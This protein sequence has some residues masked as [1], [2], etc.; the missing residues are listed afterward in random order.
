MKLSYRW[1]A[2]SLGGLLVLSLGAAFASCGGDD[3]DA[4]KDS[5]GASSSGDKG[6]KSDATKTGDTNASDANPGAVT[7]TDKQY[8]KDVCV[9][10]NTYMDGVLKSFSADASVAGDEAAIIKKIGPLLEAFG[11]DV[12][13]A[14]PPKDVKKYHDELVKTVNDTSG[15]LKAGKIKSLS[16]LADVNSAQKE[17]PADV[18]ARLA[19]AEKDV[20]ECNEGQLAGIGGL[21]G[22]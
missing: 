5:P 17:L 7:G 3:D 18:K 8:V 2:V 21:F 13:K 16:E 14:K 4:P 12:A 22:N 10:F 1:L 11:K 9:V 15:R 20:K 6:A 19:N